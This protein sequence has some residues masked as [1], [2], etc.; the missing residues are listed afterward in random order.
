[1]TPS[2]NPENSLPIPRE[3]TAFLCDSGMVSCLCQAKNDLGK[4]PEARNTLD[5]KN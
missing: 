4:G 1:M 3:I 2:L 5:T